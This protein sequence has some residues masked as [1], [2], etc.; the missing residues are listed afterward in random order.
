M[1]IFQN[2]ISVY[3]TLV[4]PCKKWKR[5]QKWW[6]GQAHWESSELSVL[7][8]VKAGWKNREKNTHYAGI[9]APPHLLMHVSFKCT[10]ERCSLFPP[11]FR[12]VLQNPSNSSVPSRRLNM[13]F[14]KSLPS[15]PRSSGVILSQSWHSSRG[16]TLP[17]RV[18]STGPQPTLTGH[19]DQL[20]KGKVKERTKW[21]RMPADGVSPL[22][23]EAGQ[24]PV[25]R[26]PIVVKKLSRQSLDLASTWA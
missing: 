9:Q 14:V 19:K 12:N 4:S 15:Q 22:F 26:E 25:R 8:W 16:V 13:W 3:Q 17:L 11:L 7:W 24:R 5:V 1:Q 18:V 6:G 10:C 2:W 20:L 23:A 21:L